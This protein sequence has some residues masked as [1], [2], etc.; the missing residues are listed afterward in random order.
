MLGGQQLYVQR[1]QALRNPGEGNT[2]KS[3]PNCQPILK[4]FRSTSQN[5][6]AR[7][8]SISQLHRW[9]RRRRD[10]LQ[11]RR[12]VLQFIGAGL[13]L[14]AALYLPRL[15]VTQHKHDLA[16]TACSKARWPTGRKRMLKSEAPAESKTFVASCPHLFPRLLLSTVA[17]SE[18]MVSR[19][20][21]T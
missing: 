14:L 4:R 7:P 21:V 11:D 2:G 13:L 18:S 19:E 8:A 10:S 9:Q 16:V 20:A 1:I 3:F 15:E 17:S 6:H 5:F 12:L